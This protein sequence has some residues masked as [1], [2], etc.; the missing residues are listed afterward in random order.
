MESE[1]RL[2][3]QTERFA[4]YI[5]FNSPSDQS[6]GISLRRNQQ[7]TIVRETNEA[8]VKQMVDV[9]TEQQAI[10]AIDGIMEWLKTGDLV[11]M[12]GSTGVVTKLRKLEN[13][14]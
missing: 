2:L 3:L 1:I 12:N 7:L 10:V 8:L 4:I 11:E 9:W 14:E 6:I 13:N 5:R